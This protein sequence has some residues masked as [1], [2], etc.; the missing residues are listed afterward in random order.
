M[1]WQNIIRKVDAS[2]EQS[3]PR[4]KQLQQEIKALRTEM[5][6]ATNANRKNNLNSQIQAKS[7][8]AKAI[9]AQS[10][11]RENWKATLQGRNLQN[12][13]KQPIQTAIRQQPQQPQQPQTQQPPNQQETQQPP[14][15]KSRNQIRQEQQLANLQNRGREQAQRE[16]VARNEQAVQAQLP[17]NQRV[18]SGSNRDKLMEQ[19]RIRQQRESQ[20]MQAKQAKKDAKAQAKQAKKDAR[21]NPNIAPSRLVP[22]Q[23]VLNNPNSRLVDSRSPQ[24]Q[25]V[26]AD[27]D[28]LRPRQNQTFSL[29]GK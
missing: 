15:R 9:Q 17:S 16:N 29:G 28:R 4:L 20:Q 12:K 2:L 14:Q 8:E 22:K 13:P 18:V 6:S 10:N 23:S 21:K 3:N 5:N 7:Q 19:I 27:R 25:Q 1:S 24:G 11:R 26:I